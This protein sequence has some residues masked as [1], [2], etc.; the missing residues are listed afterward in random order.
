M[1]DSKKKSAGVKKKRSLGRRLAQWLSVTIVVFAVAW[2]GIFLAFAPELPDT[3]ELWRVKKSPGITLLAADG[4]VLARRGGFGG[5]LVGVARLPPYLPQA[6]I[7]TEDRRFYRHFGMDVIGFA[8]AV[9][10]N[11]RAGGVVQGGSTLTQQLAK[12]LYLSPERTLMRKIR[13]LILAIWLETRL[14]KD[15]ILTLYLN[16]VY[17]GA[18]SYAV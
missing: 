14:T 13:E 11:I 6:V 2:V 18:G 16:R 7:A 17:L 12:N 4:A 3:E 15:Q 5:T 8:R 9:Y 1:A 10:S